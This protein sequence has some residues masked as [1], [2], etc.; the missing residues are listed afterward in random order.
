[1]PYHLENSSEYWALTIQNHEQQDTFMVTVAKSNNR[2]LKT[3]GLKFDLL[4]GRLVTMM[5]HMNGDYRKTV[6]LYKDPQE[7]DK[8][9]RGQELNVG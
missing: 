5:N 6:S 2:D 9:I 4:K 8:T 7:R 1:M 3:L